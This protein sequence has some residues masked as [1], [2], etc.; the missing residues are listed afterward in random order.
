MDSKRKFRIAVITPVVVALVVV[1][2]VLYLI[3]QGAVPGGS[4]HQGVTYSPQM[5]EV[6]D[7]A[8][9]ALASHEDSIDKEAPAD[10]E[11]PAVNEAECHY[12]DWVGKAVDEDAV[13]ATGRPYRVLK[14]NAMATM[15]FNP[16]RINVIVDDNDIV[17]VVRCG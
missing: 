12:N 11:M 1:A 14:P 2:V 16:E 6:S 5:G 17:T 10:A 3:L 9:M 7:P 15:D 13:K 4:K 8:D